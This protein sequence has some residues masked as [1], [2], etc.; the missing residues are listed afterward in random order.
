MEKCIRLLFVAAVCLSASAPLFSATFVV[1]SDREL[2]RAS[3]AVVVGTVGESVG[4]SNANG[5][6]ETVTTLRVEEGIGR[7]FESGE[8]I[9]IVQ[10][11]GVVANRAYVVPG[12]P[13]FAEGSRVLVLLTRH[14]NSDWTTQDLALGKFDFS[15]SSAGAALLL[16]ES[17]EI[18]GWATDGTPHREYARDAKR[19]LSY[20]R[21][22]V[23][24]Q[25]GAVDYF[26]SVPQSPAR[27]QS[28]SI[29]ATASPSQ[30]VNVLS[31][32]GL[33]SLPVRWNTF[34]SATTFVT[35]G[36]QAGLSDGGLGALD[37]ALSL[38]SNASTSNI[39]YLRGGTTTATQSFVNPQSDQVSSI[40]FNDPLDELPGSYSNGG[41]LALG[42]YFAGPGTHTKNGETFFNIVEG[43]VIVQNGL[44][45]SVS[46]SGVMATIL[47]HE[48]G[49]TLG[50]RHSDEASP[51]TTDALMA[52]SIVFG[53]DTSAT[54]RNW[55]K[56]AA[57]VVYG[58]GVLSCNGPVITQ[59]PQ[60]QTVQSGASVTLSVAATGDSAL[61]YQWL[62]DDQLITGATSSSLTITATSTAEYLAVVRSSCN[63][64]GTRSSVATISV[65]GQQSEPPQILLFAG[66]PTSIAP[67]DPAS[68]T[69]SVA[70]ATS[71]VIDNGVG[72]QNPSSGSALVMPTVTTTYTLTATGPGGTA[73]AQAIII[74]ATPG[75]P[76]I[77]LFTSIPRTISSGAIATL[78]FSTENGVGITGSI[79]Q[80]VGTVDLA[81][82][83]VQV[84]PIVTTTYTLTVTGPSGT[85]RASTIVTVNQSALEIVSFRASPSPIPLGGTATLFFSVPGAT[86]VSINNG[87]GNV[88]SRGS[89]NVSPSTT[90]TYTLTATAADG[91]T[92]TAQVT[93]EVITQPAVIVS[94]FPRGLVQ[95]AGTAGATDSFALTNVGGTA[96]T[97]TLS[98]TGNFFTQSPAS[99]TLQPGATQ[100]VT[101][102]G[103]AQ[104]PGSF[105][106]RSNVS[107]NGVPG[108]LQI[109]VRL[110]SVV[111]PV[112]T[113]ATTPSTNRVDVTDGSGSVLFT[114]TGNA[115]L[116]GIVVSD[117]PWIV[118]QSGLITIAPGA[119]VTITFTIDRS[120]RPDASSPNG[121]VTGN[122]SLVYL[123][124][125]DN[126]LTA[127]GI[128]PF[129]T[130]PVPV[131]RP[132]TVI[133]TASPLIR[134]T[135]VPP[136]AANEVAFYL[137]GLANRLGLVG[138]LSLVNSAS[139]VSLDNNVKLF[140][141]PSGGSGLTAQS[142]QVSTLVPNL[143]VQFAN[144][145]QTVF[146]K[147]DEAGALQ[148]RSLDANKLSVNGTLFST[149]NPRGFF[150]GALPVFRSDRSA[151][152]GEKL[153]LPGMKKD[154]GT[155]SDLYIQETSGIASSVK[156]D[157]FDSNAGSLKT[158]TKELA[159]FGTLEL[160]D[161]APAGAVSA[162]LTQT[163]GGGRIVG[164]ALV[165]DLVTG[166]RNNVVDWNKRNGTSYS[167]PQLIPLAESRTINGVTAR[168]EVVVMN[169]GTTTATGT[170]S[171][172]GT[173]TSSRRRSSGRGRPGSSLTRLESQATDRPISIEPG[174]TLV[175]GDLVPAG[176][177]GH[178]IFQPAAGNV[179]ITSRTITNVSSAP[180]TFGAS[181]PAVALSTALRAGSARQITALEDSSASTVA[182][183]KPGTF[184]TGFGL[185][186][187]SGKSVTVRATL[188]YAAAVPGGLA[189]V[190]A[191]ASKDYALAAGGAIVIPEVARAIFG[192]GRDS[193]GDLHNLQLDFDVVSGEGAVVPYTIST[194]NGSGDSV[195]RM[196]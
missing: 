152:T 149:L 147:S 160:Q 46:S 55:D 65:A 82:G 170:F 124:G 145:V 117:V 86:S 159:A 184:R 60:S 91:T 158:E 47:A 194:D 66:I 7:H 28:S 22:V 181:V 90:T 189:N 52:S 62:R 167:E 144:V 94:S 185:I 173:A 169:S 37:T 34:P 42:G 148:I 146:K 64:T 6:I 107:G 54:L 101:L 134:P 97:I 35:N 41:V 8:T 179:A 157:F 18:V 121:S 71:V 19:F 73:T 99:F 79:D 39:R 183:R 120:K 174:R 191:V 132:I 88:P 193:V 43:D 118:P 122:L 25:P 76:A 96:T 29:R 119:S 33:G 53:S 114:N 59:Q 10:L 163:A 176:A 139:P 123:S 153:F 63:A 195:L 100:V 24:D 106:G 168:T 165:V 135:A 142:A 32:P 164:H 44:T 40:Q 177:S 49:H 186:E 14:R 11:G 127:G 38:W 95:P 3:E 130:T 27:V 190:R 172:L 187:T 115:V 13:R 69:W 104:Q 80:G 2:I 175:I 12:S 9:K 85:S 31:I 150:G 136:L 138:D 103:T 129:A 162:T 182:T 125:T 128:R 161:S 58:T 154:S 21:S 196:E 140:Y 84:S 78:V 108:G 20:V 110:L 77:I 16:R 48:L 180:G 72:P 67:G 171:F 178:L 192:P 141:T 74:V 75:G 111:P 56:D 131:S 166:D 51:S 98:Q 143:A 30:Y 112:G 93:V 105:E 155:R 4:R 1:R 126:L 26:V 116:Q 151:R 61:S 70:N 156:I 87:V 109:P 188:R 15:T 81:S 83:Q 137:P 89:V 36:S 102:T 92:K 133:D 57:S 45:P 23:A 5:R 17:R 50:F 113:V 68:L